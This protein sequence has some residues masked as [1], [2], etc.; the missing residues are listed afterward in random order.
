MMLLGVASD[1]QVLGWSLLATLP[2]STLIA[3]GIA[4]AQRGSRRPETRHRLAVTGLFLLALLPV[5][6]FFALRLGAVPPVAVWRASNAEPWR[7]VL[8]SAV[9]AW[10]GG[11]AVLAAIHFGGWRRLRKL[12][13]AGVELRRDLAEEIAEPLIRRTGISPAVRVTRDPVLSTPVAL[14]ALRPT[15]L[16][17]AVVMGGT[18]GDELRHLLA[19]EFGHLA[20]RDYAVNVVQ[21]AIETLLWFVPAVW[22]MSHRIRLE[23]ECCCDDFAIR[24]CGVPPL[25]Y[26]RTLVSLDERRQKVSRLATASSG[27]ELSLRV[28]RLISGAAPRPGRPAWTSSAVMLVSL[29]LGAVA[30]RPIVAEIARVA[31]PATE[32]SAAASD[33]CAADA[34]PIPVEPSSNACK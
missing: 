29:T 34:P 26:A 5:A 24:A 33:D 30:V 25:R 22:W 10:A 8:V 20:R 7:T 11:A 9:S 4:L 18:D 13:R 3:V 31:P 23:R 6:I 16:V 27:G 32:S 28:L 1:V 19:H 14:G 21:I 15:V 2:G 17:P 12:V